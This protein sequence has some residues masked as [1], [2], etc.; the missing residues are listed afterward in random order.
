MFAFRDPA[1]LFK[2]T[3]RRL[4]IFTLVL[5]LGPVHQANGQ[6][7]RN[8]VDSNASRATSAGRLIEIDNSRI[9]LPD[10]RVLNHLGRPVRFYTDLIKD[11]VV[12]LSFIYTS[13]TNVCLMQG[14]NLSKVQ[15]QLGARLGQDVFLISVSMDPET[16]TPKKLKQWGRVFDTR[17]G[18]TLVSSNLAEMNSMLKAFTGNSPGQKEMH[19]SAVFIGNDKTGVW[20]TADGQAEPGELIK[21]I[22]HVQTASVLADSGLESIAERIHYRIQ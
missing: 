2:A 17:P 3:V 22:N 8:D 13:C 11:K 21:L 5:C 9:L 6:A 18:W 12:L 14:E 20:L 7:A 1:G 4:Y 15:S 19:A 10:A 16:D